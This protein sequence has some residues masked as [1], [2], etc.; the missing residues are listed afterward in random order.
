MP[1]KAPRPRSSVNSCTIPSI[2][3]GNILREAVKNGTQAGLEGQVLYGRRRAGSGRRRHR[4]PQGAPCGRTTA[5]TV[6]SWTVSRAPFPRQRPWTKWVWRSTS[7]IDIDVPDEVIES[8]L[9]GR[10]VCE[11]C[12]ASYHV[13]NKAPAEG[14]HLRQVRRQAGHPQGRSAGNH[15]GPSELF[16]MSRP[17]PWRITTARPV[18]S[19]PWTAHRQISAYYRAAPLDPGGVIMVVLKTSRRAHRNA[20]RRQNFTHRLCLSAEKR[21]SPVSPP[22]KSTARSTSSFCLKAQSRPFLATADSLEAPA[23]RSMTK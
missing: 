10:R 15:Q 12:G 18:S 23:F 4:D 22:R 13:V 5:R 11:S 16:T 9:G 19:L 8:R 17:H 14:R 6:L 3:T 20:G 7:V 21:S 2:S 1:V